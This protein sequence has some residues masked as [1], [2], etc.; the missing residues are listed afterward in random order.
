MRRRAGVAALA[1]LSFVA[2]AL[3]GRVLP[4][5]RQGEGTLPRFE[6]DPFWPKP[7]PNHWLMGQAAGVAVDAQ[8]HVW[9]VHRPRSLTEA[10]RG[11]ALTPPRSEC[12]IPA[13][14][15]LEFDGAGTLI[16]AWGGAGAGY[17]WPLNEH[18]I[19]VDPL[20]N[21]WIAG[22]DPKD[23]QVLK[24]TPDGKFLLQIGRQGVIGGDAD[25]QHLN[26]P[27]A[28]AVD[29]ETNELFVADGYGNHRVIVFDAETG[30]YKRHWGANGRPPGAPGVTP[31]GT[32]VHC[33]RISRD[34]LVYV[35]DR[36]HNRIQVF[37]RNGE[38]VAEFPVAAET[39]GSGSTW[40]VDF[41]PD[42]GQRHLYTADG[43]N[44]HVWTLRREGGQ[45][46]GAFGRSGRHAGQF[47][48]VHNLAVDSHG[49]I[50]TTEVDTGER[51]QKFV[52]GGAV[53]SGRARQ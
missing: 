3:A 23:G 20:G 12:C 10:E 16:R 18:G 8:D 37:K 31:F 11:A 36:S 39:R 33:V 29:P 1:A 52:P 15:V 9:V 35:C 42:I 4:E 26:R 53:G 24:F 40:D 7:L 6:V 22:N 25:T 50:Y 32:P 34:G 17:D 21:V 14:P 2:V 48:Y 44:N 5:E 47:H 46:L 51:V 27:A 13:P 28:V 30:A 41:S 38:F 19:F 49:D 43:E 45:I